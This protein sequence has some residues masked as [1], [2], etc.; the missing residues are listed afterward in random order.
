M[1]G[2]I[3]LSKPAFEALMNGKN[4]NGR[5]I[6]RARNAGQVSVVYDS[7]RHTAV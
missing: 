3:R 7:A 5:D 2:F 6:L 4:E 1:T